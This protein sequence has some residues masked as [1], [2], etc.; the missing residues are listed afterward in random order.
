MVITSKKGQL[1]K[2]LE[3]TVKRLKAIEDISYLCA[4]L[5]TSDISNFSHNVL[6]SFCELTGADYGLV[7]LLQKPENQIF[8]KATYG[9][10]EEFCEIYNRFNYKFNTNDVS[11]NWPSIKSMMKKQIVMVRDTNQINVGFSRFFSDS[12]SPNKVRAVASVP[13][14]VNGKP[15]GAITKYYLNPHD[16][17]D[18]EISFMKTTANIITSTVERNMLL[19]AAT[20]SEKELSNTLEELK[21]VNKELDS[22]VYIASHDLREPLRTIESFVSIL[23]E[24]LESRLEKDE[25][26]YFLRI[27][28]ATQKMRQL[29]QDLTNLSRAS[30][31]VERVDTK[32]VN[33]NKVLTET[34]FELTAFIESRKAK[35]ICDSELPNVVGNKEKLSS[36]FKNLISNGIKF[37]ESKEPTVKIS[38]SEDSSDQKVRVIFEDNGIG[39]EKEYFSKIFNLFQRLHTQ[40]EYE[41]TGAGLAIVKKILEKYNCDI[42][43]ESKLGEGSKFTITL[44]KINES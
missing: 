25:E 38:V 31:E 5:F 21:Q 35:I 6:K 32:I 28:K 8:V 30:R 3:R 10:S 7:V 22:F 36:V 40:E 44:P 1:Q 20:S 42:S 11:E 39:I 33:L 29:I 34:K 15:V 4:D 43:V 13:L 19:E 27:V 9:F 17:N 16:F 37:N 23:A 41:G 12:I 14:I 24:K 26:D 2:D 18:E